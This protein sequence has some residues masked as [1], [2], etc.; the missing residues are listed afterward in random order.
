MSFPVSLQ[1]RTHTLSF[2]SHFHFF[3]LAQ[4]YSLTR[5]YHT[6]VNE[7]L[8]ISSLYRCH[9][10]LL[11]GLISVIYHNLIIDF[12]VCACLCFSLEFFAF[13]FLSYCVTVLS[14]PQIPLSISIHHFLST[15]SLSLP[16]Y[17]FYL[18]P[19]L[20]GLDLFEQHKVVKELEK[21][22]IS[23]LC[24]HMT[25]MDVCI[26]FMYYIYTSHVTAI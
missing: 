15:F 9:T 16:P 13:A 26:C 8:L 17:L 10:H 14:Q 7:P 23:I 18:P 11:K 5:A 25:D 4:R 12:S 2:F 24:I 19:S 3:H 1:H 21:S 20:C 22:S 6:Y